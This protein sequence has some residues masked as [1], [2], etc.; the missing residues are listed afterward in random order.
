MTGAAYPGGMRGSDGSRAAARV[1]RA[2]RKRIR[3]SIGKSGDQ[4]L[5]AD[6]WQAYLEFF[7]QPSSQAV[8]RLFRT[9]PSSPRCGFCGAPFAG[10]GATIVRPFGYRPS[11]KN[12]NI[13]SSCVELSPPGGVTVEI[14]VLFAD[15]RGFT[16]F[17]EQQGA[18][19]ARAVLRRFYACAEQVFFPEALI[20]KVV[21]DAVMALY[22]PPIVTAATSRAG[23]ATPG[24]ISQVMSDHAR[25]L[26]ES[27]GYG[28]ATD[29][30]ELGVGIGMAFGEAFIGH[31]GDG[32]VHDF[33]AVGDVV[34]TAA[35]LQ[36]GAG[37]G[38]VVMTSE[39]A[40]HLN[41]TGEQEVLMLKGK[42]QS[43]DVLRVRWFVGRS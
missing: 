11:G 16:S 37:P 31:I 23:I 42:A 20:D 36:A 14:G 21:G 41:V 24:E 19:E 4:P 17:A 12:P 26:L 30:P 43:V 8:K 9:L 28:S 25:E 5:D 27:M 18:T 32:A 1:Q 38:E 13:C 39:I 22:L 34:N 7:A 40:R 35:R 6:D 29:G 15:L 10:V 3:R 2:V 33:T